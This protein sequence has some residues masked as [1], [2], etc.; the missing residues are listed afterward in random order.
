MARLFGTDGVRGTANLDLTAEIA[1]E[2]S[3]AAAHVLAEAGVFGAG[4]RPFA[5]VG[6]D[7]RASGEFLEAAVVAGLASAGVDVVRLGVIPTPGVAYLVGAMGADLGVMLSAS[8][9]PMPD[10]GIKFFARGGVKLDDAIED[11][12]EQRM[13]EHWDRPIGS[14]VGRVTEDRGAI[15]AYIAHLVASLGTDASL[16][17]LKVVIDCANGAA[18]LTALAAFDAQ[19]A[20]V[21]P[22]HA[23]PDGLNINDNCGSTHLGPLQAAVLAHG[24]DLGIALDGDAD[25]CLAVDHRGEVVD[26][27]Q[28]LAVLALAMQ[29]AKTLHSD[30]VVATVM[31]NLGFLKAMN[32]AGIRVDQTKVGDRYVL[33]AMNANGFTL[34]GEQSG[35]V[36]M[37]EYATTGDGVLTALHLA[38][39]LART[40]RQLQDLASV[41][42]RLPQVMIN[43]SNV[44][45]AWAGIDPVVN[46]AVSAQIKALG[47][48]GRVLLRPSGTEPLVRVM[49]EADTEERAREVAEQ[50]A[51]VVKER[52]SL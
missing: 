12:I 41:V 38:A 25:R 13:G 29:Q 47:D 23:S 20:Q 30:T 5:L 4:H 28:I 17:G 27:D 34:G 19:G 50:L 7:T 14:G 16:E 9:N 40:G 32:A 2:L 36:I 48:S 37:S 44:N 43:V 42:T 49:V 1:L 26:G 39:Q 24:A 33:E 51:E 31:S 3:I 46:S 8:H 35:H 11:M 18:H 45:K 10:N 6:R 21:V 52:L 22:L 15:E